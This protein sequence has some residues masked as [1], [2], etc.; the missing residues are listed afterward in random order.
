MPLGGKL[1]QAVRR[2]RFFRKGAGNFYTGVY[3]TF[4]EARKAIPPRQTQGFDNDTAAGFYRERLEK[5]F[6]AD[7]A[8]LFW[9]QPLIRDGVRVFDFGGHVGL[10]F[11]SWRKL[12][13]LPP[14]ARW[15]VA[16]VPAVCAA[17]ANVAQERGVS[18]QL[19]FT[20]GG[21]A[22]CDGADVFFSG[23]A[24]QYLDPDA[25][26]KAL[27]ALGR[28]P[29]H[30]VINKLPVVDSDG[31]FTVQDTGMFNSPYTIFS[32]PRLV[33]ALR[34]L[35]YELA[36]AWTCPGLHCTI[37]DA[38]RSSVDPYSGFYFKRA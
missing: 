12:L 25:L 19:S 10:H 15:I 23:G 4:D 20:S 34:A 2:K 9:L 38:K 33:E 32:R 13:Q 28:P 16:D 18:E 21:L 26:P 17:G 36:D 22:A 29:P 7:Y 1:V 8:A 6:P 27:E 11:Y 24:L 3:R 14:S 35:K 30:L 31:Y 5:V 37:T